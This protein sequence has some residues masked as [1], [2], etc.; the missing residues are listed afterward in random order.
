MRE[1]GVGGMGVVYEA[2]QTSLKRRVAVKLLADWALSNPRHRE[3]FVQEAEI[4]ARMRH[5][6]IVEVH[7]VG[8]WGERPY[9]VMELLEGRSLADELEAVGAMSAQEITALMLPVM[10]AV[11][12]AHDRGVVH[13]DLKPENI[14][15]AELDSGIVPKVLDFGISQIV[16]R[17]GNVE[18]YAYGTPHYMAPELITGVGSDERSDQFSLGVV[19]HE[20]VKGRLPDSDL[21]VGEVLRRRRE[22]PYPA[23]DLANVPA[24][25]RDVI[26]RAT[27]RDPAHRF[28]DVRDMS[29][30]LGELS[31]TTPV[32]ALSGRAAETAGRGSRMPTQP[33]PSNR[34][35]RVAAL[36]IG[37]VLIAVAGVG[38]VVTRDPDP[39]L[40][41]EQAPRVSITPPV[42]P[43]AASPGVAIE[44]E[45]EA[46]VETAEAA[47]VLMDVEVAE[48][49]LAPPAFPMGSGAMRRRAT[50][51][52][53]TMAAT[54]M[55]D[56]ADPWGSRAL[57][58]E[59]I[60][61]R[62]TRLDPW[63]H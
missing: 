26:L 46:A 38:F 22:E 35:S 25:L 32:I 54:E 43:A 63:A 48:P 40:R 23:G 45:S 19:L 42:L 57:P 61:S 17:P 14:F 56:T 41:L 4:A 51:M 28:A 11:A 59:P 12:A 21:A 6:N 9:F 47:N 36:A 44:P 27:Q 13:R 49:A 10:S 37:A 18:S 33:A 1:I 29:L 62:M 7:D 2:V 52:G 39:S 50:A 60:G 20:L 30:A 15:V 58:P 34:R 53:R 55:E 24:A 5:P 31:A 16:T 8:M 3:R